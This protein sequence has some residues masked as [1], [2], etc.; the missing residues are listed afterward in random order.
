MD[1]IILEA[2]VRRVITTSDIK[3]EHCD[4][5]LAMLREHDQQSQNLH[6]EPARGVYILQRVTLRDIQDPAARRAIKE[7]LGAN[8]DSAG[9]ILLMMNDRMSMFSSD[10]K[11]DRRV[12]AF[13]KANEL[14][15]RLDERQE[16][17]AFDE[18]YRTV[19]AL[20]QQPHRERAAGWSQYE[21]TFKETAAR[22][23][24]LLVTRATMVNW[25][26]MFEAFTRSAI[27][28]QGTQALVALRRWQLTHTE[29]P[30]DLAQLMADAG[31]ND[32]PRD[33]YA[34]A[35]LKLATLKGQPLIYSIGPDG[36]DD[37]GAVEFKP[38]S[39]LKGPGDILFQ[40]TPPK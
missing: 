19:V 2:M 37:A 24:K 11:V 29:P 36:K 16:I 10:G 20:G 23:M 15:A 5:L 28:R 1:F 38:Q 27:K 12:V 22:E 13:Q 6:L 25:G 39:G 3:R 17:A 34:E 30:R 7:S 35:P 18:Q 21:T 40:L 31:L 14:L 32:I 8:N 26:R 4:R 9:A 33:D